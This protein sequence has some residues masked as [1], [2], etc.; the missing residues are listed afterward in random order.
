MNAQEKQQHLEKI[1]YHLLMA[2]RLMSQ[3]PQACMTREGFTSVQQQLKS[4]YEEG[5]ELM[6]RMMVDQ[7]GSK[8]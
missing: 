2:D 1:K 8:S 6:R 3:S 5:G 7:G 4:A